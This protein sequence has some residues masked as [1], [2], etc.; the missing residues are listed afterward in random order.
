M[1]DL[2]DI[3]RIVGVPADGI[4]GPQTASAIASRLTAVATPSA[5]TQN[6]DTALFQTMRKHLIFEEGNKPAAYQDH[7]GYWTIGVGR[8]IDA[9]KG[10]GLSPDEVDYLLRNDIVKR[11]DQ[12]KDWPAWQAVK[13]NP[14]RATALLSMAFQMG[15][16]GLAGFKN[17][18]ALVTAGRWNDAAASF[19]QS[20]W[21]Q[22]TPA[23]AKRVTQMIATGAYL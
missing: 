16:A 3:Q 4:W 10:G 2:K 5:P 19:M 6:I 23:R 8:L 12:I 17:S 21:A 11:V 18:L 14:A 13:D 20:K 9:R 15:V 7:L 1:T 22:Q